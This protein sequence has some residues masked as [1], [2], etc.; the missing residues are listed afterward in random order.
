MYILS[1]NPDKQE[2]LFMEVKRFLPDLKKNT[3][4]NEMLQEMKY[5]KAC[6]K[7]ASR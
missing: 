1:K 7:E 3:I 6:F 5:L 4:T 2:R